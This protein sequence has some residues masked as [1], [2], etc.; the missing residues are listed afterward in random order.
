MCLTEEKKLIFPDSLA[1]KG[2]DEL[3]CKQKTSFKVSEK[4]HF[5]DKGET[6]PSSFP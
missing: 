5:P 4:V 2:S 3:R 1:T 6:P